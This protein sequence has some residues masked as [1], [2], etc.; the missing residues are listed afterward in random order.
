MRKV[1]IRFTLV[2]C[3]F[4]RCSAFSQ[5]YNE[6]KSTYEA[7]LEGQ[8]I[9]PCEDGCKPRQPPRFFLKYGV[10]VSTGTSILLH[11]VRPNDA[12]ALDL[13]GS[14][15][16]SNAPPKPSKRATLLS[17]EMDK[18]PYLQPYT[19]QGEKRAI[20]TLAEG[21][22]R[23]VWCARGEGCDVDMMLAFASC[24]RASSIRRRASLW[25]CRR[26]ADPSLRAC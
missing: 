10:A 17:V 22:C 18:P 15:D 25:A 16:E 7:N 14:R 5:C 20:S 12:F 4:A 1:I 3:L 13:L 24:R 21:K 6:P 19:R 2:L 11:G 23:F 8:S 26:A 9:R